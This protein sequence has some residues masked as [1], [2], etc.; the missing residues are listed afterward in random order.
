MVFLLAWLFFAG[1]VVLDSVLVRTLGAPQLALGYV[2]GA[3]SI[4]LLNTASGYPMGSCVSTPPLGQLLVIVIGIL[5]AVVLLLFVALMALW[6]AVSFVVK[7][8][9]IWHVKRHKLSL[10]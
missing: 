5:F 9:C 2:T 1:G 6:I 4:S 7:R 3:G 8:G 10:S